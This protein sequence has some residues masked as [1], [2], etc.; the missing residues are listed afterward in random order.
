[1]RIRFSRPLRIDIDNQPPRFPVKEALAKI[2]GVI[3]R[4]N[5]KE[6]PCCGRTSSLF[7]YSPYM[8]A[9]C[10]YCLSIERY[11][12]LCRFLRD[13]TDFCTQRMSVLE[14]APMWCFQEFCRP[15]DNIDYVSMD[16]SSPIAM[17]HM[18]IRDIRFVDD[19]F[20]R[21]F[22][23]HVLEHLDDDVTAMEEIHRVLKP[24]GWAII[25]VPLL[26][27]KTMERHELNE[28]E[29]NEYLKWADH[30]RV[31]GRDYVDRLEHAGFEVEVIPFGKS[32][33]EEEVERFGLDPGEDLYLCRKRTDGS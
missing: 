7:L 26:V 31:Y 33:T 22:C 19:S 1:M 6:C 18:D 9:R 29:Q 25:Q 8:T 4:G 30:V 15:L 2:R 11:R 23:Y 13:E 12:V 21:V 3:Y 20:D 24:G 27:E 14:I 10:P 16:I 32:F 5:N 28:E 17:H